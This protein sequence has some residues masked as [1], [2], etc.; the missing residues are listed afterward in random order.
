MENPRLLQDEDGNLT[1]T[2]SVH[3][4]SKWTVRQIVA[5]MKKTGKVL[6]AE[7]RTRAN[8]RT[9]MQNNLLWALLEIMA[10]A[11]NGGRTGD[12][13]AWDCY[14]DM[15]EKYGA[16]YE[17]MMCL[18]E[19]LEGLREQFRALRVVERREYGSKE[20]LVCK[21]FYGSSKFDTKEMTQLIDGVFDRLA[22]MGVDEDAARD[23]AAY[24]EDWNRGT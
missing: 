19:A 7:I 13:T 1:L 9:L 16:K 24:R 15:I 14:C 23:V 3:R 17:Y 11:D 4:D 21:C 5:D 20:M 12:T 6:S 22:E 8:R 2:V 18:P 10:L